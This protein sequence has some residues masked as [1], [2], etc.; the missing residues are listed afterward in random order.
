MRRVMAV[1]ILLVCVL[2]LA[3][4]AAEGP[5]KFGVGAKVWYVNVKEADPAWLYGPTASFNISER[6]WASAMY[7]QG[8]VKF[9]SGLEETEKDAEGLFGMSLKYA[10]VGAGF[11]Y[12]SFEDESQGQT[13]EVD[14]Y[15]PTV[16]LGVGRLIAEWPVGW[17]AG[18]TWMFYDAGSFEKGEHFNVEGGLFYTKN[19]L[20]ATLG[21][22]YKKFYDWSGLGNEYHG[23]TLG[24]MA[25]F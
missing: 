20:M 7:M 3:V 16:Y 21:Y 2:S 23:P 5:K 15:G 25:K 19:W 6:F 17:Y 8:N 22:R 11:R 1:S 9:D 24:L 14:A 12:S 18:G 13:D 4:G 10:D